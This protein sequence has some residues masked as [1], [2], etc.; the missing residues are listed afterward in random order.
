VRD[1][2]DNE[3]ASWL[4]LTNVPADHAGAE[5]IALWYHWRW[6][7]ESFFKL[8][9]S[10]GHQLEHWQ[11]QSAEAIFRRLLVAAMACVCVWDLPR[12]TDDPADR[13]KAVWIQRSGRQTKRSQSVTAPAL[14]SGLFVLLPMLQL[15]QQENG[16][17]SRIQNLAEQALPLLSPE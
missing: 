3:L 6:Q 5:T 4:L 17:L 8:L 15:L 13:L 10:H 7:M 2:Q 9:K 16:D 11:Q 1:A 14:L 12:R